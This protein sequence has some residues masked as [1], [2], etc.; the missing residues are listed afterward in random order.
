MAYVPK[1]ITHYFNL[2]DRGGN[3][4]RV[5][6]KTTGTSF[7]A[8][9][10]LLLDGLAALQAVTGL[11]VVSYGLT[12]QEEDLAVVP[13]NTMKE[14][15]EKA[16]IN[17]ALVTETVPLPGQTTRGTFLIPG[18]VDGLFLA[19]AGELRNIVDPADAALL[20][21]LALFE[22][23]A[24]ILPSYSLSDYQTISDPAVTGNVKGVRITRASR[25]G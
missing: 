13:L 10:D 19:D 2:I 18:P 12:Y 8:S 20:A 3:R 22:E 25:Q 6:F 14:G 23:G 4:F 17:V 5:Q 16:E 24:G 9:Y 21:L 15:E 11:G 7:T 1:P